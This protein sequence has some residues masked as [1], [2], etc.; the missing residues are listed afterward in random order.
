MENEFCSIKEAA[1][2]F[3]VN[4]ATIRRAIKRG[5][6]KAIKIGDGKRSPYRISKKTIESIHY[7]LT[8]NKLN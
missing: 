4:E 3:G 1:V 2:V 7:F 8:T 5:W 6:I